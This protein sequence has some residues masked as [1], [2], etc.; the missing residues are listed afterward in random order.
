MKK[1]HLVG[2]IVAA[3]LSIAGS[4]FAGTWSPTYLQIS[5]LETAVDGYVV[6]PG[7]A[8]N[9]PAGCAN[10]SQVFGSASTTAAEKE[11]MSKTLLSAFLANRKV[12]LN[13]AST[14]CSS[15]GY[16][17]YLGVRVDSDN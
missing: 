1:Q 7:T 13:V 9:N 10:T 14:T 2:L 16:P 5:N 17:V 3:T 11:L 6:Y 12:R 8:I 15:G 4:A